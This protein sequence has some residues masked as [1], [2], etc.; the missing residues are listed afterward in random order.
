[1]KP[2][3]YIYAFLAGALLMFAASSEAYAQKERNMGIVRSALR[4]LHYSVR[5]GYNIGGTSPLPLPVEI[6]GINSYKPLM[7]FSIEGNVEKYLNT[8][9]GL[10]IGLRL[11]N[12]MMSTDATVKNYKMSMVS[13]EGRLDGYWTG[14]VK[15]YVKNSYISLPVLITYRIGQRW[16]VKLGPY[17]SYLMSGDFSGSAYDGYLRK[18]TPI[19]AKVELDADHPGSYDFSGDLE[20]F[21]AGLQLGAEWKA[22]SHLNVYMDLNWGLKSV[23]PKDF[24]T[25]TFA[26]YPIYATFGFAYAF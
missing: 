1:M 22:F 23:F 19:G 21:N 8:G 3:K 25:I 4:G 14:K 10:S 9:W 24:E 5:A 6:R 15:T 2:M 17:F 13:D 20:K 26:M 12:K 16:K 18:S 7:G 11:E